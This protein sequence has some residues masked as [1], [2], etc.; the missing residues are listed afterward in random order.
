MKNTDNKAKPGKDIDRSDEPTDE[1][2]TKLNQETGL[3]S[4]QDLIKFFARGVV[5]KVDP[6]LDL[7]E[8]AERVTNDD[9]AQFTLWLEAGQIQRASDDDA[10]DW[11]A[12]E[13]DFWCLVTAPWVLVQE[14]LFEAGPGTEPAPTLH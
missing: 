11:N 9:T 4:W 1:L 13:P 8:V 14:K 5:V 6:S 12:R 7:V 10:R 3:L 2:S